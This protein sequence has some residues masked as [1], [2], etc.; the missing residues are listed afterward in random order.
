MVPGPS[1]LAFALASVAL[2]VIPGPSV[3]FVIGRSLA[4]GRAGGLL[5]VLGNALGM[6][7]LVIAVALG[8]GALVAQSVVVFTVIK[9]VGAAY[10]VYLGIQAIRHRRHTA[11]THEDQPSRSPWR[12]L[13]EGFLVGL[14]N[15]KSLV[16]FVAV[17]PQFV[18]YGAGGIP[19]QLFELGVV[20]L[21]LALLFDSIW[22][23]AAGTARQWFGRSPKR[24]ER[25]GAAGGV[26]MIGLGGVLALTGTKH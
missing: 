8:I 26:M 7:P 22:A 20:F 2:I 15:P 4:L 16:F 14:T 6:L 17:L 11:V 23:L 9:L 18:D 24:V 13:G 21:V 1:L 3:L 10:L 19:L 25:L 12:I 5:S